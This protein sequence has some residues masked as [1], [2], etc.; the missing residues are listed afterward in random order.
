MLGCT[1]L[2]LV[3]CYFVRKKAAEQAQ[4][5]HSRISLR[6]RLFSVGVTFWVLGSKD[7]FLLMGILS[8]PP[9]F[10][11]P[12]KLLSWIIPNE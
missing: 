3:V 11:L 1:K 2:G 6:A 4:A 12:C 7:P 9:L 10:R 5:W 8:A